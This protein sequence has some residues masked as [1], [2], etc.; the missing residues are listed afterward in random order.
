MWISLDGPTANV[1]GYLLPAYP[2]LIGTACT[3]T[4]LL[5]LALY[6]GSWAPQRVAT[7]VLVMAAGA[8]AAGRVEYVL[9]NAQFFADDVGVAFS[10][11]SG[12]LEP[13]LALLAAVALGVAWT[14][15]A[16]KPVRP[17]LT[18]LGS[19]LPLIAFAAWWGCAA[20]SCAYGVEV[21]N[22]QNY[23]SWQ[24]WEAA[25]EYLM[26]APRYAVQPLGMAASAVTIA[27]VLCL[28]ALGVRGANLLAA[29]VILCFAG[30][31]LLGVLR[32]DPN[33][34]L[35]GLRLDQWADLAAC[36]AGVAV[37]IANR[38]SRI[39]AA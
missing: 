12:G 33:P 11:A 31:S 8:I 16:G 37:L 20:A 18:A 21:D 27:L 22:L 3:A 34:M 7:M 1:F 14:R 39:R 26:V 38:R 9:Y 6:A 24:V 25:G 36:T 4:A 2:L 19:G 15:R 17:L 32:G 13:R 28:R 5:A 30:S 23:P 10:V 35:A 29:A